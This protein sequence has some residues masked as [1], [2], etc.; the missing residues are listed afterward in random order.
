[1]ASTAAVTGLETLLAG[2]SEWRNIQT[3][4]KSTFETVARILSSH[5]VLLE[6]LDAR[7][8]RLVD[9]HTPS[10]ISQIEVVQLQNDVRKCLK[11]AVTSSDLE[12]RV[13]AAVDQMKRRM[14]HAVGPLQEANASTAK[15]LMDRAQ[16]SF[17]TRADLDA[18]SSSVARAA[19][20][21]AAAAIAEAEQRLGKLVA[22]QQQAES[23]DRVRKSQL[24]ELL[25][26]KAT[27]EPEVHA[28][29]KRL[30]ELVHAQAAWQTEVQK[31]FQRQK[32]QRDDALTKVI[33]ECQT[34][35]RQ[36]A[37]A[38]DVKLVLAGKVDRSELH[39][40]RHETAL[41]K[42]ALDVRLH[43]L[44]ETLQ[45]SIGQLKVEFGQILE[46]KCS[47]SDV[48]KIFARKVNQDDV[49][50]WLAA[51]VSHDELRDVC[52]ELL[53]ATT[54]Q[55]NDMQGEMRDELESLRTKVETRAKELHEHIAES[56]QTLQHQ[57]RLMDGWKLSVDDLHTQLVTKMG[58]KDTCTLLDTKCNIADVNDALASLQETLQSK[59]DESDL[60]ALGDDLSGLRRQMRGELCLGRWIWKHGRP[61]EVQTI[62]WNVQIVN[63][64]PD[65]F[66]W[67]KGA[68][69]I[70]LELP[71]LYM[72][73]AGFFTD[74][75]P[76]IHIVVNGEPALV[77]PSSKSDGRRLRHSAGNV[78]GV[79]VCEFLALPPRARLTISYDIDERAQA[80][81]TL[82]KL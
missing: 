6:T 64:S 32:T 3:I 65:I 39:D 44:D 25:A 15:L 16:D 69:A 11:R 37:M 29:A 40:V 78:T 60:K 10:A 53:H 4:V 58:I 22:H 1:M 73:Q 54:K 7:L 14:D 61:S 9:A 27:I 67:E 76:T 30:P 38:S 52:T 13:A 41:E 35:L 19:K 26:F 49:H 74:Y 77:V 28:L 68:D 24:H 75:N 63:T 8:D 59:A 17:V 48:V 20:A 81:L 72:L 57:V 43:E 45:R 56:I 71:G 80:C 46:K 18:A 62:Q 66:V 51:K 34:H 31:E 36:R 42:E 5:A 21:S 70:T 47:K 82:R 33:A 50:A 12:T 23:K 79:S 2:D 55:T